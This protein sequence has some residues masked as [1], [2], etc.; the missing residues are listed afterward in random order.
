[1]KVVFLFLILLSS[2]PLYAIEWN[3]KAFMESMSKYKKNIEKAIEKPEE[4]KEELVEKYKN[5]MDEINYELKKQTEEIMENEEVIGKSYYVLRDVG[6]RGLDYLY[7]RD[8]YTVVSYLK[9]DGMDLFYFLDDVSDQAPLISPLKREFNSRVDY[10]RFQGYFYRPA[11]RSMMRKT[12][13]K[14]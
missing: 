1:M 8:G 7:A 4:Y 3:Q 9:R 13:K 12:F 14:R 5:Q 10:L 11:F 2:F 6:N